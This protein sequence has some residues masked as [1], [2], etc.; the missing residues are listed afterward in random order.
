[1]Y[2][3]T[4]MNGPYQPVGQPSQTVHA[5]SPPAYDTMRNQQPGTAN[6]SNLFW[7]VDPRI[8]PSQNGHVP[9]R[10]GTQPNGQMSN[11]QTSAAPHQASSS[12]STAGRNDQT[13]VLRQKYPNLFGVLDVP[14]TPNQNPAQNSKT[15]TP[16]EMKTTH[17]Q[18]N[19]TAYLIQP[20][21]FHGIQSVRT[22]DVQNHGVHKSYQIVNGKLYNSCPAYITAATLVPCKQTVGTSTIQLTRPTANNQNYQQNVSQHRFPTINPPNHSEAISESLT[23]NSITTNPQPRGQIWGY[24]N[25]GQTTQQYTAQ[26]NSTPNNARE[27]HWQTNLPFHKK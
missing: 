10:D 8:Q 5:A 15:Q 13:Y 11:S 7:A 25:R 14:S 16:P 4:Q 19:T 24:S 6:N 23:H 9:L 12:Q 1:M 22:Q 20:V 27:G 21:T 17:S 26:L 3:S 18:Q 2:Y